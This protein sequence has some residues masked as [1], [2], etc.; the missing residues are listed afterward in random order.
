MQSPSLEE[1][2]DRIEERF[3]VL[4]VDPSIIAS[5]PLSE[6]DKALLGRVGV[7]RRAAPHLTIGSFRGRAFPF[8]RDWHWLPDH[9][10]L[11][12]PPEARVVA[13]DDAGPVVL[14]PGTAGLFHVTSA[15]NRTSYVAGTLRQL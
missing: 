4:S 6:S 11:R 8:L 10:A 1:V 12:C 9:P 14:L 3:E 2:A 13:G 15:S 5:L 7:P